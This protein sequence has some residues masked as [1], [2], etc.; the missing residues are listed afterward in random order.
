MRVAGRCGSSRSGN[1][2]SR[3]RSQIGRGAGRGKGEISG[4][5]GSFKKKKKTYPQRATNENNTLHHYTLQILTY[6]V[7]A[8]P[9]RPARANLNPHSIIP[10]PA[11]HVPSNIY[12]HTVRRG[13]RRVDVSDL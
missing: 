12:C 2:G 4:G 13:A 1:T 7:R 8:T 6:P 10:R 5:A 11:L 3:N 9:C